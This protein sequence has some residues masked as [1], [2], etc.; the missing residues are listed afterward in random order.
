MKSKK[1]LPADRTTVQLPKK[2]HKRLKV[3]AVKNDTT[4]KAVIKTAVTNYWKKNDVVETRR[5]GE[6]IQDQ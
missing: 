5:N 3:F 4:I 2:F 6:D 1:N